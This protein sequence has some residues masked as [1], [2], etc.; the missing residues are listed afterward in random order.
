[1]TRSD[2]GKASGTDKDS[3][4]AAANGTYEEAPRKGLREAN[5]KR[6]QIANRHQGGTGTKTTED[7]TSD[8]FEDAREANHD[9]ARQARRLEL[10]KLDRQIAVA[11]TLN[12]NHHIAQSDA[13]QQCTQ[14]HEKT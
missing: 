2:E 4:T 14:N 13:S 11:S 12:E 9:N 5:K 3:S 8:E 7:A 10:E 1:M 6:G